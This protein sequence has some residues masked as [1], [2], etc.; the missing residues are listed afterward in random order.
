MIK[1]YMLENYRTF[2]AFSVMLDLAFPDFLLDSVSLPLE[3]CYRSNGIR[4]HMFQNTSCVYPSY[5]LENYCI[6]F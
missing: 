2:V 1:I 6:H 4:L 5:T 3:S